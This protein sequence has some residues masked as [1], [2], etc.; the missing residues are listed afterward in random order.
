VEIPNLLLKS[1][2]LVLRALSA[3]GCLVFLFSITSPF[4]FTLYQNGIAMEDVYMIKLWS[5]KSYT[6]P[7]LR[8]PAPYENWFF[9][10]WIK[11]SAYRSEFLTLFP[12]MFVAQLVTL[13]TGVA[14]I[15]TRK[16]FL[17]YCPV[18]FCLIVIALMTYVM[19]YV[20]NTP[21]INWSW[22]DHEGFWLTF[23]S[24]FLFLAVFILEHG[25]E[26]NSN[27]HN[28]PKNTNTISNRKEAQF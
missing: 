15:L 1:R 27:I 20:S 5:F 16:R 14:Y 21:N 18:V 12:L 25:Q 28:L 23:P 22:Q 9:D 11:E 2:I 10:Y 7:F 26:K 3:L 6:V 19:T 24:F 4:F 13:A 17:A 8:V